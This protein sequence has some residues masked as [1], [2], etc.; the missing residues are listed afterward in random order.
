MKLNAQVLK[1]GARSTARFIS[2]NLPTILTSLGVVAFGVTVYEVSKSSI[3]T[4]EAI[5]EA[6]EEKGEDLTKKEKVVII[7]KKCWKAFLAG[8]I[9]IGFFCGANHI[10]LTRQ[11]ALSA[12]YAM[13]SNDFKEYKEKVKETIGEKK[14]EKIEDDIAADKLSIF[15][16]D[17]LSNVPGTGPLWCLA[18]SN[19]PFRANLEDIRQITNDFNDDIY[20]AKGKAWGDGE[21]RLNDFIDELSRISTSK[22]LGKVALGEKFGWRADLTGPINLDIRYAKAANGEPCGYINV[23]PLLLDHNVRDIYY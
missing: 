15:S 23:K 3:A 1:A 20:M 10:S 2:R 9:T 5:E 7:V 4:K 13:T 16:S 6:E 18:W 14:S 17:E 19:T 11:A 12:A 21:I 8:L 22:T